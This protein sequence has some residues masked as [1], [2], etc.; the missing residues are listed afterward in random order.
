MSWLRRYIRYR[1]HA[2][3]FDAQLQVWRCSTRSGCLRRRASHILSVIYAFVCMDHHGLP[4]SIQAKSP[5]QKHSGMCLVLADSPALKELLT[6]AGAAALGRQL[7]LR[8]VCTSHDKFR[9]Q[10]KFSSARA[11]QESLVRGVCTPSCKEHLNKRLLFRHFEGRTHA[12]HAPNQTVSGEEQ[13]NYEV[14]AFRA[15]WRVQKISPSLEGLKGIRILY[16]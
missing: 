2:L 14:P 6:A 8:V 15:S 3:N 9:Q 4:V 12:A 16:F 1:E 7:V 5:H 11:A 13:G 10:C